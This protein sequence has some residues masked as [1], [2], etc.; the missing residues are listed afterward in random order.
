M[1]TIVE[2]DRVDQS[3]EVQGVWDT[4]YTEDQLMPFLQFQGGVEGTSYDFERESVNP[5][6]A[7]VADEG[8]LVDG[9][10]A[11][12]EHNE[13]LKTVYTQ[14]YLNL[15]KQQVAL[16]QDPLAILKVK[17]AKSFGRKLSDL[18]INGDSDVDAL[19]FDG[20][21]KK[22]RAS[23]RMMAM[24]DGNIDG[25]G[26]AETELTVARLREAIDS[27]EPGLPDI[28]IMNK[29]MRRKLTNL[30]NAAGSGISLPSID[31]FGRRVK[32]FDDIPIVENDYIASDEQY[33]DSGSWG[34]STATTIYAVKLGMDK[35]GYTLLHN[36]GFFDVAF[37]D[38]GIRQNRN[39]RVFRLIGYPGSVIYEPKAIMALGG[40]DSSA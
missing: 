12:T 24:D 7:S 22:C 37:Q 23:T 4:I 21:E 6:A 10:I 32:T 38:L 26:A 31:M 27:V 35:G 33:A 20:L 8:E 40:I 2:W 13:S 39:E 30:M 5:T 25:P 3:F 1:T 11:F 36:G 16:K 14:N 17:M 29:T 9:D 19:E 34:S 28:L 15:K 18:V